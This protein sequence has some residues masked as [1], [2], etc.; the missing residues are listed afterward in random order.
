MA[1]RVKI[2]GE[3]GRWVADVEGRMLGVLHHTLRV[4]A[5]LYQA[6]I[7]P[8]HPGQKRFKELVSA[9]ESYDLVVIQRDKDEQ[10]LA[11]DG[12]VGVFHFTDLNVDLENLEL[13]LRFTG[14]Y[15][16]PQR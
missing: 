7:S 15:A 8:E 14:R 10:S 11:R 1:K 3:R 16:D 9:L 2:S 6:K 4:G 13:R 12:Y 5:D